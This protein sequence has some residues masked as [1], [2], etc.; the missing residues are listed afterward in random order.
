MRSCSRKH[1]EIGS[2]MTPQGKVGA[3]V[4]SASCLIIGKSTCSPCTRCGSRSARISLNIRATP[5][6]SVAPRVQLYDALEEGLPSGQLVAEVPVVGGLDV[7]GERGRPERRPLLGLVAG[8]DRV[9]EVR[10]DDL[11]VEA[12]SL[13]R[14]GQ[15]LTAVAAVVEAALFELAGQRGQVGH[16]VAEPG[17]GVDRLMTVLLDGGAH[18]GG[19]RAATGR[20]EATSSTV[21]STGRRRAG[22]RPSARGPT[23]P[24]PPARAGPRP[25]G[26]TL[27]WRR[28]RRRP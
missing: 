11:G 23:G 1:H 28:A 22:S 6:R 10:D 21:R 8:G 17:A 3:V 9:T 12:G 18:G 7:V 4:Y 20:S 16:E 5:C 24:S 26:R 14:L 13:A 27:G 19:H 2:A 15:A 25:G